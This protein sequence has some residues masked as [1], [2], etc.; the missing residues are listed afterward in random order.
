MPSPEPTRGAADVLP[1]RSIRGLACSPVRWSERLARLSG[2][3]RFAA[4]FLAG[5]AS[6][7]AIAPFHAW[8]VLYLSL[9]ALIWLLDGACLQP[10][11]RE[12]ALTP[13]A[14][15]R[16][17]RAAAAVGWWFGFG[18]FVAGL[19][20]VGDAFLVEADVFAPLLPLAVTLLPAG[21]ALFWAAAAALASAFWRS[22]PLRVL[23]FALALAAMEYARGH[24]LT[25]FPWNVLGYA[26][27]Y[28]LALMQTAALIGI[29]GL[30]LVGILIWAGPLVLVAEAAPG[31]LGRSRRR[32]ALALAVVPVLALAIWGQLR[33]TS[34]PT[35]LLPGVKLR[36][37]QPS[38]PQREKWR[39][40]NQERIFLEH[41]ELSASN[42]AG[43]PDALAGITHVIWP[44]AA[45][46][47]LP[48]DHPAA[49]AAIGRLLPPG[50]LLIAGGL[51]AEA[52]PEAP[53]GRRIFNSLLVFGEGGSFIAGYDKAHLVPFGEYLPLAGLLEALGLETLTRRRGGFASG[54]TPRPVLH[55]PGLPPVLP[56]ICYEVIFPGAVRGGPERPALLINLT[57][58][59]WFG[60][61]TGPRQHMH[62]AR[63]RAVEAGLPLLRAANNGI[64]ALIDA[65]GRVLAELGL[66]IRGSADAGLPAALP[67]T[68]YARFGDA[69]FAGLWLLGAGVLL[70]AIRPRH[71]GP[72]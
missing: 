59:G 34:A 54:P 39:P 64:S 33:L 53:H 26:L 19:Y 29:Y 41:L 12:P 72:A 65:H 66:D 40:E 24:V 25:G 35:A 8:P 27:T 1:A 49:R 21:L 7:T 31:P 71:W 14:V 13:R 62:Q 56:L 38:I 51:R 22:G 58:D 68:P 16:R 36:I 2:W 45:M 50:T 42:A 5:L 30:T 61:T 47:F 15:W 9:P 11:A 60:D 3:R 43:L 20:W 32:L 6:V 44:E 46:P 52:A 48:V 70:L 28:P 18:Y 23:P 67:P 37:V 57:N 55:L 69:L 10:A 17:L 63:V 4:A